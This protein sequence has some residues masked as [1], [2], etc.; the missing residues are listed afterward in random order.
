[1]EESL[2]TTGRMNRGMSGYEKPMFLICR[3]FSIASGDVFR[4]RIVKNFLSPAVSPVKRHHSYV[5]SQIDTNQFIGDDD[6][7]MGSTKK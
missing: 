3:R 2:Q 7:F 6:T 1:M 5:K 4:S